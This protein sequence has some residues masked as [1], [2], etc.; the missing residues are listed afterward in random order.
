MQTK[1]QFLFYK[2]TNLS[3]FA[4][5]FYTVFKINAGVGID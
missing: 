3:V 4:H 1:A 2:C 5:L